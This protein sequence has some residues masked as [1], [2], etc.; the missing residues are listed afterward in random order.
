MP[1]RPGH[2]N[3]TGKPHVEVMIPRRMLAGEVAPAGPA[4]VPRDPL[5]RPIDPA[6][7]R[8]MARRGG[9]A[10]AR[11]ARALRVLSKLGLHGAT[12]EHLTPYYDDAIA[13]ADAEVQRLARVIGGGHCGASPAIMVQ[14]AAL[15]LA[16]SRWAFGTGNLLLGSKLA[17]ASR[18]NLLAA[19]EACVNEARARRQAEL[20]TPQLS[21]LLSLVEVP[22][23][24]PPPKA[25]PDPQA[26]PADVLAA[27][28]DLKATQ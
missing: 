24:P 22:Q 26:T 19:H 5:G 25:P 13:F 14:N 20:D 15:Q 18:Q 3:G 17:D 2:G 28:S 21:P 16:G 11:K 7:H 6:A 23:A 10:R 4:K 27:I 12:P 9:L 8:E 1:L